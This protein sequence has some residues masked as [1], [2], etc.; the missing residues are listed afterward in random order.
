MPTE[1]VP[2]VEGGGIDQN[3]IA[4][5]A[6]ELTDRYLPTQA[7]SSRRFNFCP[8]CFPSW[9]LIFFHFPLGLTQTE[10]SLRSSNQIRHYFC[11]TTW[12]QLLQKF[13]IVSNMIYPCTTFVTVWMVLNLSNAALPKRKRD[14]LFQ[15]Y[16]HCQLQSKPDSRCKR[17]G[18]V[19]LCFLLPCY[20]I[21]ESETK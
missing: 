9:S 11:K 12:K 15:Q 8:L 18:S 19:S 7:G 1:A 14:L 16:F 10:S 5:V 13:R 20:K 4:A 17:L 2:T 3:V 6:Q 21:H